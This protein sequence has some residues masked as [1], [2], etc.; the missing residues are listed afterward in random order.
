MNLEKDIDLF[1]V[2]VFVVELL[3]GT[4]FV[5]VFAVEMIV[6][7]SH[8]RRNFGEKGFEIQQENHSKNQLLSPLMMLGRSFDVQLVVEVEAEVETEMRE[9]QQ[10]VNGN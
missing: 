3:V 5:M 2:F 6:E 4:E 9:L 7:W 8:W 10:Q 1:V